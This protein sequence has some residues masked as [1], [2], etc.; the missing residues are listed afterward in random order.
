MVGRLSQRKCFEDLGTGREGRFISEY[1]PQQLEDFKREFAVRR[2][3]KV[4]FSL[5][6]LPV[7]LLFLFVAHF[8]LPLSIAIPIFFVVLFG[9]VAVGIHTW[10]C[11]ACKNYLGNGR[12]P[13]FC[14][15]CGIAL[16]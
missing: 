5:A 13:S 15:N 8:G 14:P 10:R 9:F 6:L 16:E 12:E 1:T 7:S 2:Q 4:F 3:R 11:P